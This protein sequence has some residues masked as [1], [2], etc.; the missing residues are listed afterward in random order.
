MKIL[1]LTIVFLFVFSTISD[2]S[3]S[4]SPPAVWSST[5][6]E[7]I[8]AGLKEIKNSLS[9]K[10]FLYDP[11]CAYSTSA[12]TGSA[13][14]KEYRPEVFSLLRNYVGVSEE[15]YL[16]CLSIESLVPISADSKSGQSFWRSLDGT[17]VLKTIKKYEC[18]NMLDMLES[19]ALHTMTGPQQPNSMIR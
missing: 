8:S 10:Q 12:S 9:E 3:Q 17:I 18:H 4:L 2:G 13:E 6:V 14:V 11:T 19:Y 16:K 15:A 1:Y 5:G 7:A